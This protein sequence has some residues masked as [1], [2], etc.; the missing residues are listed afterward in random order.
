MNRRSF[1]HGIWPPPRW[2]GSAVFA[3]GVALTARLIWRDPWNEQPAG[4]YGVVAVLLL[5]FG[6]TMLDEHLASSREVL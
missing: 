1:L 3:A 4:G 5:Y 2:A 6:Y